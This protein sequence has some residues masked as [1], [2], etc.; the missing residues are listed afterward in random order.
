[1]ALALSVFA[2]HGIMHR[3][4]GVSSIRLNTKLYV[5]S[6]AAKRLPGLVWY[7]GS[8]LYL[9]QQEQVPNTLTSV[10]ILLEIALMIL[11]GVLVFLASMPF[12]QLD[13]LAGGSPWLLLGLLPLLVV[14]FRPGLLLWLINAILQRLERPPLH[15]PIR[16]SHSIPWMLLYAGSWLAGGLLLFFLTWTVHPLTVSA[17]PGVIGI[18]ALTGALRL[19]AFFIPGAWGIQEVSLSLSLGP[20]LPLPIALG[21]SLLFRLWVI[22]SELFWVAACYLICDIHPSLTRKD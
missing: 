19:I 4:A 17:L 12:S 15:L 3:L 14:V 6:L 20:Y 7:V 11:S 18:V 10:G 1:M 16:W 22:V 13:F 21:V 9:Y 8:R 2:W 5:Y